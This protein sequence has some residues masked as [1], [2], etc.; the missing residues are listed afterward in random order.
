MPAATQDLFPV[1]GHRLLAGAFQHQ[2]RRLCAR[3]RRRQRLDRIAKLVVNGGMVRRARH[4]PA[5]SH[6]G[7]QALNHR[8]R[9]GAITN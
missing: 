7:G 6:A 9:H 8:L 4:D 2:I 3:H 1:L 5:D